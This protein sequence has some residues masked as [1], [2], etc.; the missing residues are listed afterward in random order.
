MALRA[1]DLGAVVARQRTLDR[2]ARDLHKRV[3][4]IGGELVRAQSEHR[5]VE[6]RDAGALQGGARGVWAEAMAAMAPWPARNI[7]T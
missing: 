2:C 1:T 6:D 5:L 4:V 3:Y 7:S